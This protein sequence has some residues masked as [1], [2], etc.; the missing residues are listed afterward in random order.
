MLG[1][2]AGHPRVQHACHSPVPSPSQVLQRVC[3]GQEPLHVGSL[4][5]LGVSQQP[6]STPRAR[7]LP[8]FPAPCGIFPAWEKNPPL[9]PSKSSISFPANAGFPPPAPGA[10]RA[11]WAEQRVPGRELSPILVQETPLEGDMP[12]SLAVGSRV[13][14]FPPSQAAGSLD[15]ANPHGSWGPP[16]LPG[17]EMGHSSQTTQARPSFST[18]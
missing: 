12:C 10:Y 4:T 8:C 18:G 6:G 2:G 11:V 3:T 17:S 5:P 16:S 1:A 13:G 7:L 9:A 15:G 14:P